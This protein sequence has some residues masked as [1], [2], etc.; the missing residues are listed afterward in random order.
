MHF[1]FTFKL[2]RSQDMVNQNKM[3]FYLILLVKY[4]LFLISIHAKCQVRNI[5][6]II[7]LSTYKNKIKQ[8]KCRKQVYLEHS[9][10]I[11]HPII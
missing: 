4:V 7:L 6:H 11:Y 3:L 1:F 8:Y 5:T 2:V 10:L 9:M